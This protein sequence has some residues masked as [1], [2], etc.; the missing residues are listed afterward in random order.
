M[1]IAIRLPAIR[2]GN[3]FSMVL[4]SSLKLLDNVGRL[5]NKAMKAIITA[6][7]EIIKVM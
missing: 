7:D 5:K 4:E 1:A 2:I 3:D 6:A